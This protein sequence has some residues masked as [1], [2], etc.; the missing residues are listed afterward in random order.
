MQAC[1][2]FPREV[3]IRFNADCMGKGRGK[4]NCSGKLNGVGGKELA[5]SVIN[6]QERQ[7]KWVRRRRRGSNWCRLGVSS[8]SSAGPEGRFPEYKEIHERGMVRLEEF[9]L[10]LWI[11]TQF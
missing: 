7:E 2:G 8:F 1:A 9:V 4:L 11:F 6:S 5:N 3:Q 10:V